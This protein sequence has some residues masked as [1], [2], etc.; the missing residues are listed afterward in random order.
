MARAT[1]VACRMRRRQPPKVRHE[2]IALEP[3]I[4]RLTGLQLIGA[5]ANRE[6]HP[7]LSCTAVPLKKGAH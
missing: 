3:E 5:E 4:R 7:R 1:T 6:P 2:I